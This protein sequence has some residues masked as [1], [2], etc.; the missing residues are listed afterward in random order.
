[1][2]KKN[3]NIEEVFEQTIIE[4]PIDEVMSQ[5]F[6]RYSKYVLQERAVPDVRDGLKPVQ[7][8]I[9]YTMTLEPSVRL[10]V[11]S[12]HMVMLLFMMQWLDYL[13]IGK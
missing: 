3:V 13:K 9:V 10:L 12:I 1:M 6:G 8:R 2:A 7:R 4:S 5:G 11:V